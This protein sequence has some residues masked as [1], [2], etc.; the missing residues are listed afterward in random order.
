[1]KLNA[2]HCAALCILALTG[3]TLT[4][5]F[6]PVEAFVFV[7]TTLLL[8]QGAFATYGMVYSWLEPKNLRF[9]EP[10]RVLMGN[11]ERKFSLLIPARRESKVI[12]PTLEAFA[13][14][15]YPASFYEV[16]II[17][18][19]DDKPTITAVNE[20][21]E[22]LDTPNMRLILINTDPIN[23]AQSLNEGL[24]QAQFPFVGVFDAEDEPHPDILNSVDATFQQKHVD[25]VQSGIQLINLTPLWFAP[26]NCLE[27][28]FWFKSILPLLSSL[29]ATPLGGNT[30]FFKKEV[31][32]NVGGWDTEKLTEDTDIGVRLSKAGF[33]FAMIYTEELATLEETPL[34]EK[35]FIRQRT[36][37]DQGYLQVLFQGDWL[38]LPKLSQQLL[39][40]YLLTQPLLYH[41]G[42]L[43]IVS[44]P[45]LALSTKV[46]LPLALYSF[47]P[48]YFLLLQLGLK[49]FGLWELK[50]AYNLTVSKWLFVHFLINY[51][52]YQLMLSVASLRAINRMLVGATNWEKTSHAN[53]HRLLLE[54]KLI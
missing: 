14:L 47:V 25:V 37:W 53:T 23:K 26:F 4:L 1:M 12:G 52:P 27:Y 39:V 11:G 49:F 50:R 8:F 28:Y 24:A 30:V 7:L 42:I 6:A 31:L 13:R 18:R 15:N 36:R 19:V 5:H 38:K 17:V 44:T 3:L 34:T 22:K 43:G 16:L 51:I 45:I 10:P 35:E 9:L 41:L 54:G 46:A 21:L 2:L 33:T 32:Q 48:G 40:G 20:V 29:G